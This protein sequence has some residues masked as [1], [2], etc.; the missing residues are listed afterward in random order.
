M[1]RSV[2]YEVVALVDVS[3]F[4]FFGGRGAI[5]LDSSFTASSRPNCSMQRMPDRI[6][7]VHTGIILTASTNRT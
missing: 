1:L 4:P 7:G 6:R 5:V 2:I 3:S